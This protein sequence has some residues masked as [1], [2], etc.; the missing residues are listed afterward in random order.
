MQL[1]HINLDQLKT[2]KINVRKKGG[3]DVD[4]LIPSIR[5]LGIVQPL[6]VWP[7]CEGFEIIA[8]QR[9]Y[10]ALKKIALDDGEE[11]TAQPVPCIIMDDGDDAKAIEASL[12]EN[13]A[14]LPMDEIDQYKAFAALSGKGLSPSDIASQFGVSERLV[15]QR[16]AIANLIAPVLDLYRSGDIRPETVRT[17]TLA[18]KAQQKEWVRLYKSDD[19]YAPQGRALKDWLFGGQHIATSAALFDL[20]DYKGAV[21][22]DLFGEEAYFSDIGKFWSLQNQAIADAKER[23]LAKSWR[24]V[25]VMDIGEHWYS[26]E[27]EAT[28]KDAGGR[29]YIQINANGEVA[30]HEGYLTRKE[31][32]KLQRV[33]SGEKAE[34]PQRPEL[35][36]PMQN[37][38]DLH[39]HAAVRCQLLSHQGIALR[40]AVAQ[41]IAGSTLWSCEADPQKASNDATSESLTHNKAQSAFIA[42]RDAVRDL[43]GLHDE[44][45]ETLVAKKGEFWRSAD[46]DTVFAKLLKMKDKDVQ[47]VFTFVVAETL[48][49]ASAAV[50]VLG[51]MFKTN[52]LDVWQAD[53][54]FLDLLR[55]KE[56]I[57]TVLADIGGKQTASA[58]IASTAKVQKQVIAQYLDGTRK[59]AKANWKPRYMEFP[60]RSYTRRGGIDAIDRYASVKK[61]YS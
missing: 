3:S 8:G 58:H 45:G 53:Q 6:L 41:I 18:T 42:E 5:S 21:V 54:T 50:E 17:L 40:L 34:K 47:R 39:R 31:A 37:Y 52:M 25:I 9:R 13:I 55:D 26:W 36:G 12:A 16:M 43:L 24:E 14:R 30:C 46:F 15:N 4:D 29:V 48:P 20:P 35:T 19:D 1:Q 27:H 38:L 2:T 60:M 22:S 23:Y 49:A 33:L 28:P 44:E 7:N 10:N 11:N 57:N 51:A 32:Q 56:A 61:Q 59:P